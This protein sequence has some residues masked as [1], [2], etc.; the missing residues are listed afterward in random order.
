[1][2]TFHSAVWLVGI[3]RWLLRSGI[4]FLASLLI[5]A[6]LAQEV[7]R[8]NVVAFGPVGLGGDDTEIFQTA[9]NWTAALGQTLEIPASSSAYNVGPLYFPSNTSLV[10]DA[11]VVV[12]ARPGFS[13]N[14]RLLN[15]VNVKNV[16][17]QGNGAVFRMRKA[18]YTSGEYRHW[19][20]NQNIRTG[21]AYCAA[22]A[23]RW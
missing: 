6:T 13:A 1:M 15:I 4:L 10:L 3:S 2:G 22:D 20:R 9:L 23:I 21:K 14:Q 16:H 17:V 5:P 12:Q 8:L 19:H 7:S 11:G 18:E